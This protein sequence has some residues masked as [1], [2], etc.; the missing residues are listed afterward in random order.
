MEH[1]PSAA[2][3]D[4]HAAWLARGRNGDGRLV[5]V[6]VVVTASLRAADLRYADFDNCT[7]DALKARGYSGDPYRPSI[8]SPALGLGAKELA[9]DCQGGGP[10]S[11]LVDGN[12][13][14][15]ASCA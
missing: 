7:F 6:N 4:A 9:Y 13:P 11:S 1:R 5:L 12:P 3:H 8:G 15:N 10:T 14:P 2:E